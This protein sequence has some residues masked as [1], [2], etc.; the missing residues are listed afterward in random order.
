MNYERILIAKLNWSN[1]Y[2]G[3]VPEPGFSDGD[4]FERFNFRRTAKG[5]FYGS[6]PRMSP[7][8]AG[9]WLVVFIAQQ[10]PRKHYAVGW[11]ENAVFVEG[12]R[13]EYEEGDPNMPCSKKYGTKFTY[14]V[15]TDTAHLLPPNI[16]PYFEAPP[17]DHFESATYIF[18]RRGTRDDA[19]PWRKEFASFAE[20]VATG[21][22]I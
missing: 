16:R 22:I 4:D 3:E 19:E 9:E 2:Q 15:R 13:P 11:Y 18:A 6:I 10:A 21:K 14:S 12:E 5:G 8:E 7:A 20:R 1:F 17:M